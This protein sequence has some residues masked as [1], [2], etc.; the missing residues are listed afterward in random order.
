MEPNNPRRVAFNEKLV[1]LMGV[2]SMPLSFVRHQ[3]FVDLMGT[4]VK[5]YP[6]PSVPTL[7]AMMAQKEAE[8]M[9]NGI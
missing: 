1:Y 5:Q 9:K 8:I 4:A 2:T 3:A 7:K 6:L